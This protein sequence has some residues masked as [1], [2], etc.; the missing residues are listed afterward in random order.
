MKALIVRVCKLIDPASPPP[1]AWDLVGAVCVF[2]LP[3]AFLLLG[4][5]FF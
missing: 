3:P 1:A 5:R 4:A 2:A